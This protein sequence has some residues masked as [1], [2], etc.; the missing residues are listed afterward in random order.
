MTESRIFLSV[1]N[2]D[3]GQ[4][5][6]HVKVVCQKDNGE[7]LHKSFFDITF[8]HGSF[9]SNKSNLFNSYQSSK[10]NLLIY[11]TKSGICFYQFLILYF[12][13]MLS[14]YLYHLKHINNL[15]VLK[16]DILF[17]P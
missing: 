16:S 9:E 3:L 17:G 13:A 14:S 5:Y 8:F 4:R 11:G 12:A 6:G 1:R 15:Y 10:S 2:V 7:F